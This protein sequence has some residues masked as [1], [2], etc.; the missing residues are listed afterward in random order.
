MSQTGV[1]R[2]DVAWF[3]SD[4]NSAQ[5]GKVVINCEIHFGDKEKRPS[6]RKTPEILD[7]LE[8]R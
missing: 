1:S 7:Q 8:I 5:T 6:I 2:D 4:V 3:V